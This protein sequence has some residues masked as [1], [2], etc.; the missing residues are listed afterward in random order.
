VVPTQPSQEF[1]DPEEAAAAPGPEPASEPTS[2][3]AEQDARGQPG[4]EL[5]AAPPA[6]GPGK[7]AAVRAPSTSSPAAEP[8]P[9]AGPQP[10]KQAGGRTFESCQQDAALMAMAL[11]ELAE[12]SRRGLTTVLLAA[13][14]D[15]LDIARFFGEELV[16]VPRTALAAGAAPRYYR[17]AGAGSRGVETVSSALPLEGHRQY[18]DLFDYEYARLPAALR[19]LRRSVPAREDV[20]LFAALLSPSEWALVIARRQE[21]LA[22]AGRD[23]SSVRQFVLRYAREP[24]GTFDL[25]M[26]EIVFS[27][28]SRVRSDEAEQGAR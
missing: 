2:A 20:Y 28:G 5:P 4:L 15:Q 10:A 7:A 19:E 23:L 26:V 17:L 25:R 1:H 24:G 11:A 9:R 8:P 6:L 3:E 12:G 13:P 18:R 21:A 14:E 22:R 16:L 27:D